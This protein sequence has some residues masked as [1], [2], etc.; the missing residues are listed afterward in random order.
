MDNYDSQLGLVVSGVALDA[1]EKHLDNL[2]TNKIASRITQKDN[3]I[4]GEAAEKEASVRLAWVDLPNSSWELMEPIYKLRES[5]KQEGVRRFVLAGMGGSSLAPEVITR[6]YGVELAILDS[7]DPQQV[8][9][10]LTN[11]IA[12]TALII[13]SKSGSTVETDAARRAFIAA[14][15]A[16][17]VDPSSRIIV[18]T[19]PGSNLEKV[20]R[21]E[22]YRAIFLADPHVGGRYSALSAFGLVPSGL[23]GVDISVLLNS[24]QEAAK[25]FCEDNDE[26]IALVLG[27]ALGGTQPLRD[28]IV[29]V[30]EGANLPGFLDWVEQLIA[31]STGKVG[32]GVLPV[33]VEEDS[34]EL[35]ANFFDALVVRLRNESEQTEVEDDSLDNENVA[36]EVVVFGDLGA[37]FLL[38]EYAVVVAGYLLGINPFDQPDVEA[39][40]V[41]ARSLLEKSVEPVLPSFVENGVEV[42]ASVGLKNGGDTLESVLLE[43]FKLVSVDGYFAVHAYLDRFGQ[44]ELGGVRKDLATILQRPVTFGWGPRFLHST[45]Q[46]HKGGPAQG[47]FLQITGDVVS[48][49]D[50]AG[51]PFT[52]GQLIK[53]QA[54]GDANVLENIGR[55]VLRL[56]FVDRAVGVAYL[57]KVVSKIK[58]ELLES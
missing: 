9:Q 48:D 29:F 52:F 38:W 55:P 16:C 8:A 31:E 53:A 28:K 6:T 13:A 25:F 44:S 45:G 33:I 1:V 26:N 12:Q 43:L 27:A 24:A 2:V 18:I 54:V 56:N 51:L 39:A 57:H 15:T 32:K 50:I 42:S 10:Q 5:L 40:K 46:Y 47:V 4:W 36:D 49:V 41:A 58:V 14:F 30:D 35:K 3:T 23:A 7:T 17:G 21:E 22:D 37:Q 20:A 11:D 19:D 34:Y